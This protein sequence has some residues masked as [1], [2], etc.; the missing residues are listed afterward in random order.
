M[1]AQIE[2]RPR[3]RAYRR[4]ATGVSIASG[5]SVGLGVAG[6][7]V[8]ANSPWPVVVL[9][10]PLGI[11]VLGT[12]SG[13]LTFRDRTTAWLWPIVALVVAIPLIV[14]LPAGLAPAC[15]GIAVALWFTTLIVGGIL[16]VIV[17]PEGRLGL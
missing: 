6:L 17:D 2:Q 4:L 10:I 13:R 16:E 1:D 8:L 5:V 14:V 3:V 9:A 11:R 15:L 12:M 7:A